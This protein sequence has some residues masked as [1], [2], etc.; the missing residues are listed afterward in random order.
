MNLTLTN[1]QHISL[2]ASGTFDVHRPTTQFI[3]PDGDGTPTMITT[4]NN[5]LSLG[6]PNYQDMSFGHNIASPN[7]SGHAGYTQVI[8]GEVSI[9]STGGTSP[10]LSS[11]VDSL[12]NAKFYEGTPA[13]NTTNTTVFRDSPAVGLRTTLINNQNPK[14]INVNYN[15]YLL[16]MPD[17][18]PGSNIYVPLQL[19][20]WQVDTTATYGTPW[21]VTASFSGTPL[22]TAPTS[23]DCTTFP[24][25]QNVF[26]NWGF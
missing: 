2:S 25:W 10:D 21:T 5:T 26:N 14:F 12:D 6:I 18:G 7:F 17:A 16:F 11:S 15:T 22:V 3:F 8:N 4:N 19:V 13:V 20:T 24:D 23:V 1:G 9:A